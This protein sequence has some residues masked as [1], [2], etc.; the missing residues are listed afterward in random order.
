MRYLA[1]FITLALAIGACSDRRIGELIDQYKVDLQEPVSVIAST[2]VTEVTI[3][4]KIQYFIT[5]ISDPD[6]EVPNPS[7][8]ENLEAFGIRDFNIFEPRDYKGK[9]ITGRW[10]T[11]DIYVVGTYTIPAPVV[12][13]TGPDGAKI[14]VQGNEIIVEVA[15]VIPD[16]E[17]PEDIKDIAGPVSLPRDYT[18]H[19]LVGVGVVVFIGLC[20][21]AY[22]LVRRRERKAFE[23]PPRP[24]HEIAYEQLQGIADSRFVET[25]E[26]ETY[27]VL[28]SA[29]IRHYLENRFDL[30]APEMTTEEFLQATASGDQLVQD[31]R[32]LLRDFL[33]ECD[34]VKFARYGPDERQIRTAFEVAKR[35]V[36]ETRSDLVREALAQT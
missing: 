2:D 8:G 21:M 18:P 16:G 30:H 14:E 26:I 7:F 24:A 27:Y 9:I 31:H 11:L 25:G 23:A 35:F 33:I 1:I 15:G 12:K 32:P 17:E 36:D 3:G 5:I 29:V 19:I 4:G 6:L 22:I 13:Y 34:L 20:I 28:L 10:Y